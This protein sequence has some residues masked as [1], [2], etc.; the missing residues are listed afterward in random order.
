VESA[1]FS[2]DGNTVLYSAAWGGGA[3][4]IFSMRLDGVDS[5]RLGFPPARVL[6]TAPGE[7]AILLSRTP[8]TGTLARVP[9]DGGVP[10]EVLD[11]VQDADWTPDGAR[12][13]VVRRGSGRTQ[14]E[15]PVG[16][17]VYETGGDIDSPRVSPKADRVAFIDQP[18]QGNTPGSL[19]VVDADGRKQTLSEGWTDAGGVAWSPGGDEVWFSAARGGTARGL[20]AVTLSGRYRAVTRTPSAMI[21]QDISRAGRLLFTH[22]HQRCEVLGHLRGETAERSLSWFD[23][24]HA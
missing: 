19:V 4:E 18:M 13:A 12:F 22:T 7:M 2:P 14:L 9:L 3:A 1:R 8:D 16:K 15:F 23:W 17:L 5:R 6:G 24:T 20:H 11:D 10:R 21:L